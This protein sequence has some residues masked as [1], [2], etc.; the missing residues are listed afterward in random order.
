[1]IC[2]SAIKICSCSC[3]IFKQLCCYR[4]SC[5]EFS[6]RCCYSCVAESIFWCSSSFCFFR[7]IVCCC[8][9]QEVICCLICIDRIYQVQSR[10]RI[11][12]YSRNNL[13]IDCI[14]SP[15]WCC[16]ISFCFKRNILNT[17]INKRL[18]SIRIYKLLSKRFWGFYFW[19]SINR[20]SRNFFR[21][22]HHIRVLGFHSL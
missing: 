5:D 22:F 3:L 14:S 12:L 6:N 18:I 7:S 21:S 13:L 4:Q 16:Y 19:L 1:M 20:H 9:L 17:M 15:N 2:K 8:F 11:R 10:I